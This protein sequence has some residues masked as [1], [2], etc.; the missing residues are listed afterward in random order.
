MGVSLPTAPTTTNQ[1]LPAPLALKDTMPVL[2]AT[3]RMV[4]ID[5]PNTAG[6]ANIRKRNPQPQPL[7]GLQTI[8]FAIVPRPPV[9]ATLASPAPAPVIRRIQP[10]SQQQPRSVAAPTQLSNYKKRRDS[11]ER[12]GL[13]TPK[14]QPRKGPTK[15]HQ[16]NQE[17][18]KNRQHYSGK[19]YCPNIPQ[20]QTVAEWKEGMKQHFKEQGSRRRGRKRKRRSEL[21]QPLSQRTSF[22]SN[23]FCTLYSL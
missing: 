4:L 7:L 14:Y 5:A 20:T 10:A 21:G 2:P 23:N 16:C 17:R 11:K 9:P 19:W 18:D 15:C 22:F 12:R 6:Q 3:K 1:P 13:I 8:T